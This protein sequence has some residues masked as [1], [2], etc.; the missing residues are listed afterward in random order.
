M[1]QIAFFTLIISLI[2]V[3]GC[4]KDQSP[5][6][7]EQALNEMAIQN[8]VSDIEASEEDDYFYSSLDD[9]TEGGFGG[10]YGPSLNTLGRQIVPLRFGRI[11]RPI[12]RDIRI[13]FTSDT[14]ATAM[15]RKVMR[16]QFRIL[17]ADTS[18]GD[19]I[20][21]NKRLGHQFRRVAHFA[22]R[23]GNDE[24]RRGWK[25]VKFSM[26]LGESFGWED[27]TR[28][29][30][31]LN[32]VKLIIQSDSIDLTITDPLNYFQTKKSVFAFEPGTDVTLTVH[33]DN[34]SLNPYVSPAGTQA[35]ELVR[36]HHARHR[37][38]RKHGIKRFEWIGQDAGGNNIYQGTWTIGNKYGIHHAAIDVI[39]NGTIFDDDEV[40]YPYNSVTWSTPYRVKKPF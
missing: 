28:V 27:S 10:A 30:T 9:E 25:L 6:S 20:R 24:L 33:I 40:A 14:T 8:V 31:D 11:A 29:K 23:G 5:T 37:K 22:K 35:T 26:V 38:L 21:V 19:T 4:N 36:L 15:F 12:I 17:A 34:E 3:W 7:D 1:K 32:I 39:D 2:I 18:I 13:I 16:G